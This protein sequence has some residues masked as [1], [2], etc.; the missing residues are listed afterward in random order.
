ML[1]MALI[2]YLVPQVCV[3]RLYVVLVLSFLVN[4]VPLFLIFVNVITPS[5]AIKT[6][7][8]NLYQ[9]SRSDQKAGDSD[10]WLVRVNN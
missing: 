10:T 2:I 1:T 8:I 5:G 6:I 3:F 9:C 4:A 7:V